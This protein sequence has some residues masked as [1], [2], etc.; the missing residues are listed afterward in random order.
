MFGPGCK[1]ATALSV[2]RAAGLPHQGDRLPG[3]RSNEPANGR[4]MLR[5]SY[6]RDGREASSAGDSRMVSVLRIIKQALLCDVGDLG[7]EHLAMGPP[8]L[9]IWRSVPGVRDDLQLAAALA[10]QGA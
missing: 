9:V 1:D 5:P 3:L 8:V 7:A 10:L 2:D 6:G 4:I